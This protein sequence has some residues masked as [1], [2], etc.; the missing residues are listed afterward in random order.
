[1]VVFILYHTV[2]VRCTTHTP[3]PLIM[4][5]WREKWLGSL[6]FQLGACRVTVPFYVV[7]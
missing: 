4:L 3:V 2:L 6:W 5:R 1:M 7:V